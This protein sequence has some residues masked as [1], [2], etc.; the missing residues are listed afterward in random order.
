MQPFNSLPHQT[1]GAGFSHLKGVKIIDMTTSVAGPYATQLLADFG[2]TVIKVEKR[3]GGDDARAW[4]PPFLNGESLWF[5]SMNRNKHSITLD[6]NTEAGKALLLSLLEQADILVL[7]MTPRVQSKLGLSYQDLKER[8]PKLI[9]ASLTGFGL[10]GSRK[11]YPCYDLIAEGY[12]GIMDLTGEAD[13]P[14]QK[15][16]TP[17][18]DLLAGYDLAL[19]VMAALMQRAQTGQGTSI[20]V[21]MIASMTRFCSPRIMSYLGSSEVPRRSG[22]KDSVIA[23]YQVFDTADSPIS[24]GLGNNAIWQ[25]FWQV[26]NEPAFGQE[27][28][29]KDNTARREY[30]AEI[31]QKISAI[32]TTQTR[33]YW[34]ELFAQNR[35]PAGPINR[36]DEITKDAELLAQ[37]FFFQTE[38]AAGALPQVGL[39]IRMGER[40]DVLRRA[41]PVLGQDT[42]AVLREWLGMDAIEIQKHKDAGII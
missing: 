35:I 29:F 28:T 4:G 19:S 6:A 37:G 12:S 15:V 26:V 14:P 18:A 13:T 3:D 21:S 7:N 11:D 23:I 5:M 16:G 42:E 32:L 9:H 30:R 39:G 22:G 25:R 33:A 27:P 8:L 10:E 34:L 20:D 31:V 40:T 17:A 1:P 38:G 2:A 24:L 41:P 36:V